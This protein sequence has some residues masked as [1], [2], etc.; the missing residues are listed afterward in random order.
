M[1]RLGSKERQSSTH[2]QTAVRRCAGTGRMRRL[3][4]KAVCMRR[5]KALTQL[6]ASWVK[7]WLISCAG[8][9]RPTHP[10]AVAA[11]WCAGSGGSGSER[12][13]SIR[14]RLM[15][16]SVIYWM[17]C[18]CPAHAGRGGM[19]PGC[20]WKACDGLFVCQWGSLDPEPR[21]LKP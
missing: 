18:G 5:Y 14:R 7:V 6:R 4:V 2:P 21:T 13:R 3:A 12:K 16:S 19:E 10:S 17:P 11:R 9:E 15:R 20:C 1:V 8:G